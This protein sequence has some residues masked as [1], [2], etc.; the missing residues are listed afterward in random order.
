LERA[1]LN[2][3]WHSTQTTFTLLY[4]FLHKGEQNTMFFLLI[5]HFKVAPQPLHNFAGVLVARYNKPQ[6]CEQHIR[7]VFREGK[8]ENE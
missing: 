3:L 4:V 7:L 8:T 5:E 2:D 6:A 1:I